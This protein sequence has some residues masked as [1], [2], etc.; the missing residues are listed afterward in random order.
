VAFIS[1][2]RPLAHAYA[3]VQ[4]EFHNGGHEKFNNGE[5]IDLFSLSLDNVDFDPFA[6]SLVPSDNCPP[7]PILSPNNTVTTTNGHVHQVAHTNTSKP[8]ASAH[9]SGNG[10]LKKGSK[11]ELRKEVERPSC[12]EDATWVHYTI[13]GSVEK[14]Q[15]A[16]TEQDA[17]ALTP[18]SATSYASSEVDSTHESGKDHPKKKHQCLLCATP[19]VRFK[20]K[21]DLSRHMHE[22]HSEVPNNIQC[23]ISDPYVRHIGG[24]PAMKKHGVE[25]KGCGEYIKRLDYFLRGHL[26]L[27]GE[28]V[29]RLKAL[30]Q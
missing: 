13:T 5:D 22:Q 4:F 18:T 23:T 29:K 14:Q 16:P 21:Y 6:I 12:S 3:G 28:E 17:E 20:R 7:S 11:L 1:Q 15:A 19:P 24:C 10:K 8:F 27:G 26:K 2:N 30:Y 9:G 25:G